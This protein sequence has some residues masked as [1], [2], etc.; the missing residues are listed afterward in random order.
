MKHHAVRL[1]LAII[2]A[3]TVAGCGDKATPTTSTPASTPVA[4]AAAE[5]AKPTAK[6]TATAKPTEEPTMEPEPAESEWEISGYYYYD[7]DEEAGSL[8][9][10][11]DGTVDIED[12]DG[13]TVEGE[14]S[15]D[16]DVVTVTL[17]DEE[18]TLE[19]I[20]EDTLESEGG[21]TFTRSTGSDPAEEAVIETS[22]YYYLDGDTEAESLYFYTDSDVVDFEVPGGEYTVEGE[23]SIDGSTVY[24]VLAADGG[25]EEVILEIIDSFT[26]ESDAGLFVRNGGIVTSQ[27]YYLDDGE[28]AESLYF[29]DDGT[30]DLDSPDQE[31]V[32]MKYVIRDSIITI[33][34]DE[35]EDLGETE[36]T[37]EI[38]DPYTLEM[39]DGTRFIHEP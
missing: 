38:L 7:G 1:L 17:D 21:D 2:C 18:A 31:T 5:T 26:L 15:I 13:E 36:V 20:D 12:P 8:Y 24:V 33:T 3:G 25:E 28:Y 16:G 32:Q 29:Y 11:S 6:P 34:Y 27:F 37:L 10:Y 35:D 14:Y 4:S 23:Y 30:V 9:F 39:E 22:E 19:I